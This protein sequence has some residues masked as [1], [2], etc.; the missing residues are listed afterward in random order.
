MSRRRATLC[1]AVRA[2]GYR[3]FGRPTF[4]IAILV[5]AAVKVVEAYGIT[6]LGIG[7]MIAQ[8]SMGTAVFY[9]DNIS[10]FGFMSYAILCLCAFHAVFYAEEYQQNALSARV[11]RMGAARYA[12]SRGVFAG[13]SAALCMCLIDLAATFIIAVPLRQGWLGYGDGSFYNAG[14]GSQ[15]LAGEKVSVYAVFL[16][17]LMMIGIHALEAAFYALL[18][19]GISAFLTNRQALLAVPV[20]LKYLVDRNAGTLPDAIYIWTPGNIYTNGGTQAQLLGVSEPVGFLIVCL[21]ILLAGVVCTW[22]IYRKI[23]R[24]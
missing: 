12:V 21:Y 5:G 9:L 16:Y 3:V 23:K 14:G 2:D 10:S 11:Q 22:I 18:T 8:N 6:D 19:M 13:G 15:L 1:R 24:G 4:W 7:S 17:Y 20:V